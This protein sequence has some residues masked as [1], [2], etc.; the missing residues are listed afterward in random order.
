MKDKWDGDVDM[1]DGQLKKLQEEYE[2]R[3]KLVALSDSDDYLSLQKQIICDLKWVKRL[4]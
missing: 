2:L 3:L 4:S 1:V